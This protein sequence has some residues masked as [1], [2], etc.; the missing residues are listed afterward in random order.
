MRERK[1][2][3]RKR[4]IEEGRVRQRD[5]IRSRKGGRK[6]C[7]RYISKESKYAVKKRKE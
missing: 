5:I 6:I 7:V 3:I 2:A 1:R 4:I